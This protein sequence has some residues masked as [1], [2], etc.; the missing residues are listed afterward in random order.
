[1]SVPRSDATGVSTL[2]AM[3]VGCFPIL[4]DLPSQVELV[5]DGVNG[6]RVP[7]GDAAALAERI[8]EALANPELRRRALH[9]NRELV[10][11]RALWEDNMAEMESWYYRLA[12]GPGLT[13]GSDA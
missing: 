2:E 5:E 12:G 9:L 7:V 1:M 6:F 4:S 10:R 8:G 13:G 3:A 11:R